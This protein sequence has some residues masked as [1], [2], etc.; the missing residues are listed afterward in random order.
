MAL[1]QKP[2]RRPQKFAKA[3]AAKLSEKRARLA[4]EDRS[5]KPIR[6]EAVRTAKRER[7]HIKNEAKEHIRHTPRERHRRA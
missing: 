1:R 6:R 2:A 5:H 4:K 3:P 7:P